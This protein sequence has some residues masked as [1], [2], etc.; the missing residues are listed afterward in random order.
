[1]PFVILDNPF[2]CDLQFQNLTPNEPKVSK[3]HAGETEIARSLANHLDSSQHLD[4]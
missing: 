3:S 4:I 1:M 2:N